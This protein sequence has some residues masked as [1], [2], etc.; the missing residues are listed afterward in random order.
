M[1]KRL[2]LKVVVEEG[3]ING[4]VVGEYN[5][6]GGDTLVLDNV[7]IRMEYDVDGGWQVLRVKEELPR[8]EVKDERD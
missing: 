8:A 3:V 4:L 7:G 6:L 1:L 2:G 5:L